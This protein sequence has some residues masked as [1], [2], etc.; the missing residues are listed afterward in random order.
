MSIPTDY[1]KSGTRPING[2]D[3]V[4]VVLVDDSSVIRGILRRILETDPQIKVVDSVSNGEMAVNSAR[5]K[6]PDVVILDIEMPVMDGIT[7]LPEI[8]K[9]SPDTKVIMCSSLTEKG[10]SI[11][12]K[13]MSLGAVECIVKPSSSLDTGPGSPFQKNLIALMKSLKPS[14]S[15]NASPAAAGSSPMKNQVAGSSAA[16]YLGGEYS[17]RND[18]NAYKGK[19]DIVAIG[20]S[21][22]GPQALFSV[23]SHLK[24]LSVPI[25]ITQH[26]P[27]TFT[28]TLT[29]HIQT[30]TGITSHEADEGM[31]VQN[32]HIYVARG[33]KH[34]L[35]RKNGID[36]TIHLD[37]GPPENFCKPAVDPMF[38]S[39]VEIYGRKVLGVIL[40][41]MGQDGLEGSKML[42]EKG[43]RVIAQDKQTSV[44]WGMP[45][46][47]ATN[48]I[49]SEVLPL[50]EIGPWI[51]KAVTGLSG[52]Y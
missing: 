26:M 20:S 27:A 37:D 4:S 1:T 5:M 21:T 33:G 52:T 10:A 36:L 29:D 22:G 11:T 32:G 30:H 49:C 44:V 2:K 13:A 41:G 43:G 28:K 51:K 40:T 24:G 8:L 7:A 45:G 12:M 16:N 14:A 23:L 50:N 39:L 6:K 25:V 19:P 48:G 38:R 3:N 47:V 18:V 46:A 42:V 35:F 31:I 15:G 34:M 9:V 17:L